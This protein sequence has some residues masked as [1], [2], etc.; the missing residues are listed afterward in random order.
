MK[1]TTK[2]YWIAEASVPA[3]SG[4]HDLDVGRAPTVDRRCRLCLVRKPGITPT[5]IG[6]VSNH[7][8][9]DRVERDRNESFKALTRRQLSVAGGTANEGTREWTVGDLGRGC[10][11]V[12]DEIVRTRGP[13][14]ET[15][16]NS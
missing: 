2:L 6:L 5:K 11:F 7:R 12:K 15:F 16:T 1:I 4:A 10:R 3:Y 13:E 14:F 9:R 8:I